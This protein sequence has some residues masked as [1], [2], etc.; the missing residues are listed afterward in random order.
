MVRERYGE[1]LG[2]RRDGPERPADRV[3]EDIKARSSPKLG[4]AARRSIRPRRSR[5]ARCSIV[6]RARR[7]QAHV[8]EM[9][10]RVRLGDIRRLLL[11][12]CG[13]VLP[14][15]DAGQE[16]L[17]DLLAVMS[18]G[19]DPRPGMIQASKDYAPWAWEGRT[20]V[21]QVKTKS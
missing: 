9:F 18:L 13:G 10:R 4:S 19:R 3:E 21:E 12:R 15:D 1:V 20:N 6:G 17:I 2:T 7:E 14:D 8:A 5:C 11:D 16:Y